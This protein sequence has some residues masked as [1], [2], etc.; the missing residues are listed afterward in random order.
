MQKPIKLRSL[1]LLA[2]LI[3]FVSSVVSP[4]GSALGAEEHSHGSHEVLGE[5]TFNTS[6]S[7]EV[8][9]S[10]NR[11]AALLHSFE[12]TASERAFRE[13]ALDQ[14]HCAMAQW[15]IA[16]SRYH[17][18]WAVPTPEDLSVGREA[19]A[20]ARALDATPREQMFI[21]AIEAFYLD[22]DKRAHADRVR[23]YEQGMAELAASQPNDDE[24]QIFYALSLLA[25]APATD[26]SHL[27]QRK[28]AGILEPLYDKLPD[29]P[30]VAHYLIHAYDSAA[31]ASEGLNAARK[32]AKLA[33]SAPHALHMP[34]HIF[35]RL[36]FWEDSVSSNL[37]ARDAARKAGDMGEALHAMDYLTYAY[38]QLGQIEDAQ[39]IVTE[40]RQT[41]NLSG[42]EFKIGYA[43]NAMP[44]RLAIEQQDWA[45]ASALEPLPNSTPQVAAIV[46]WARAVGNARSG[47]PEA[48]EQDVARIAEFEKAL[49]RN[50]NVYWAQQAD[51][52]EFE[53]RAWVAFARGDKNEGIDLMRTIAAVEDGIEKLPL[54]P[55]PIVPA[56][57]QLGEMLLAAGRPSDA[58]AEFAAVLRTSPGRRGAT[59]GLTRARE[60]SASGNE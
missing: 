10:F 24:A 52:L 60:L 2:L 37:A 31:L 54:T 29:H 27:K 56:R 21:A 3:P 48:A 45:A 32:Y 50:N 39:R 53:G 35:T 26:S 47:K 33:A 28:A 36:G 17:P 15:G 55:G 44:V 46:Y 12:Y 9:S 11:A 8:R 23:A 40:V 43:G 41:K 19:L 5:V 34:S 1:L 18:L 51:I 59:N 13:V 22:S 38:L 58:H 6:C 25:T 20:R 4:S 42:A 14:P 30:G 16:M 7:P 57:E 49:A